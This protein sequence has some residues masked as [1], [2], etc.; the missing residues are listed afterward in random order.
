VGTLRALGEAARGD[1]LALLG[2]LHPGADEGAPAGTGTLLLLGPDGPGF[3]ER[4]GASAEFGDGAADPLNRW[5]ERI[6]GGL[7]ARFGARAVFPFGGPPWRP[8]TAWARASGEAWSSP[9]GLL[10]H[11]RFGLFVS[12][13]GALAFPARLALPPPAA[14]PCDGCP[15]PCLAACPVGALAGEGYDLAACH[16]YLDTAS[17]ADCM[18]RGCAVRRACPVGAGLRGEAQSA[19]HM[20]AFHGRQAGCDA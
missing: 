19:F 2:G 1:G 7:A 20:T 13:R 17:G 18:R 8:F 11:A 3:W 14:R 15:A 12:Y 4:F 5:S 16:G 10:V 9:V 6:V